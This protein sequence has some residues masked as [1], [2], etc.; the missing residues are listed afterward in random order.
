MMLIQGDVISL[1]EQIQQF[2]TVRGNITALLGE[3]KG[4]LLL[5]GSMYIFSIGSNDIMNYIFSH[6][7]TP[8]IFIANITA[9]YGI[10][11]KVH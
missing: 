4:Q 10:H 6:P 2:A 3:S 7:T 5:Q 11:L 9:I 8:E 1:E